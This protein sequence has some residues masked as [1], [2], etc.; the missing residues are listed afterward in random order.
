MYWYVLVCNGNFWYVFVSIGIYWYV[1][2][3]FWYLLVSIGFYVRT[4]VCTEAGTFGFYLKGMHEFDL[5]W[6]Q[7]AS[8]NLSF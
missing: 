4:Y 6:F 5:P 8:P 7:D 1:L 2:F 3:F